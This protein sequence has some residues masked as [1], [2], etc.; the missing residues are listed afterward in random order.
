MAA[1]N[2]FDICKS[3]KSGKS[4]NL[5]DRSGKCGFTCIT[6]AFARGIWRKSW[7]VLKAQEP[8]KLD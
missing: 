6:P 1:R 2:L 3:G 5:F 7:E 8:L 4:R